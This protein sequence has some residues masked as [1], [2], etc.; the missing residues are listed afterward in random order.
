TCTRMAAPTRA[1]CTPACRCAGEKSACSSPGYASAQSGA[2]TGAARQ[3]R[4]GPMAN[5]KRIVQQVIK[6]YGAVIDLKARP[7][8]LIDILRQFRLE[9][10]D[11]D[12]GL[13]PGG[14]PPPPPP[15]P[16]GFREVLRLED[17]MRELLKVS[18]AVAKINQHLGARQG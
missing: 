9:D 10:D 4:E 18:R 11:G 17:V 2:P 14:A 6:R 5:E 15:S 1:C 7:D 3:P 13:P 8:I 12:G 16:D